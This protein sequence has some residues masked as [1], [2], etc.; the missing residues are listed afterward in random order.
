[1]R[2][3]KSFDGTRIYYH[4]HKGKSPFTLVFLHGVGA[5][6]T[7]WKKEFDYFKRVGF[8]LLAIDMRGHGKSDAPDAMS[9]YR[10]PNFSKDIRAILKKEKIENFAF[11]GHSLGGAV[12]INY[13]MLYKSLRPSAMVL[14]ESARTYPFDHE[15][16][17]NLKPYLT[18]LLRYIS[19][20]KLSHH[21]HLRG[22]GDVDLSASGMR[23]DLHL[24]SH[25][26]HLT[27]LR[28]IVKTL[29]NV[30]KYVFKNQSKID[31]AIR[32]L[33]MP[34]LL[35]AGDQDPVIPPRF[36]KEIQTLHKSAELRV[37]RDNHHMV[38]VEDADEL[39]AVI[40]EF[41]CPL[42]KNL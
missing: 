18:H 13:C 35:L 40:L 22:F 38:V 20:H 27:P 7:I 28:S 24:L 1:M 2:R 31:G 14:V 37:L 17:L 19:K 16:L 5:N 25:L 42:V 39:E 34:L 41:L 30:E 23:E 29:D 3:M 9:K 21:N 12:A 26:V 10:L 36:T 32:S 4:Y 11:L 8:S 15:R 6:W 33:E